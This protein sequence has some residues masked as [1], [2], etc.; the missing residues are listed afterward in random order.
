MARFRAIY[1]LNIQS[2]IH[3]VAFTNTVNTLQFL[4][5]STMSVIDHKQKEAF[6]QDVESAAKK[7]IWCALATVRDGE[8]RVRMVHPTWEGDTLWIATGPTSAKAKEIQAN[9]SVDI[10]FQVAPEDFVHLLVRGTAEILSD[11]PTKERI[12]EVMDYDLAQ[13]WPG[14]PTSADYCVVKVTPVRV[15]LSEMFG[16]TNKR[17][18]NA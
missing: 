16:T 14:G 11:Q 17:V 8:A 7:A 2:S 3:C 4:R 15:E 9:N 1:T 10:Q 5:G 18:W 12:W 13:F 6:F